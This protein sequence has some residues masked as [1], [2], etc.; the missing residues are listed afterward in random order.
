[1]TQKKDK[2]QAI[3]Y[4]KNSQSIEYL[5]LRRT[6]E[7][8]NIW[9]PVTGNRDPQDTTILECL[10]RE[11]GEEIGIKNMLKVEEIHQ[12]TYKGSGSKKGIEFNE[13]VFGVEI[14]TSQKIILQSEPYIEHE[15]YLWTSYDG[16]FELFDFVEQKE[17]LNKLHKKL[18]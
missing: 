16:A 5:A 1:M 18:S 2:I 11:L 15:D 10:K 8:G 17:A 9:Q 12:F 14:E 13:I 6:K 3:V 7:K 4:R